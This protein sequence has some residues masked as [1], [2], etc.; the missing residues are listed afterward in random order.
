MF[1]LETEV[2]LMPIITILVA[3]TLN[4][5]SWERGKRPQDTTATCGE[6]RTH[7]RQR[8]VAAV[9]AEARHRV[10]LISYVEQSTF[11]IRGHPAGMG[12]CI[13]KWRPAYLRQAA[14]RFYVWR[15][16]SPVALVAEKRP[17]F[18]W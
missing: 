14:I 11:R 8:A 6:R 3:L 18:I 16:N 4:P 5:L 2:A 1:G 13:R 17:V 12:P 10:V 9:D 15:R 7:R